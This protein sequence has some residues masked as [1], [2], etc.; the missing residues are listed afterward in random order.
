MGT[1]HV[2]TLRSRAEAARRAAWRLEQ[3]AEAARDQEGSEHR[4]RR[5]EEWLL[6]AGVVIAEELAQQIEAT[7]AVAD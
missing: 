1:V 7:S 2:S 5:L 4:D 3:L 6:T